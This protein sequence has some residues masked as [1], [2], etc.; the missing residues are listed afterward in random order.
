[1]EPCDSDR[2]GEFP[3][4]RRYPFQAIGHASGARTVHAGHDAAVSHS[5]D[6]LGLRRLISSS[7][8]K[9]GLLN[10]L[11]IGVGRRGRRGY[12]YNASTLI[13]VLFFSIFGLLSVG[14][15]EKKGPIPIIPCL[16]LVVAE[17]AFSRRDQQASVPA[18]EAD[19]SSPPESSPSANISRP[20]P[21]VAWGPPPPP[22]PPLSSLVGN[23]SLLES[24]LAKVRILPDELFTSTPTIALFHGNTTKSFPTTGDSDWCGPVIRSIVATPLNPVIYYLLEEVCVRD[25]KVLE[26][27]MSVRKANLSTVETEPINA[28]EDESLVVT[29]WWPFS[30][31]NGTRFS[32]RMKELGNGTSSQWMAR[33]DGLLMAADG[34]HL[35]LPTMSTGGVSAAAITS[36][37]SVDGSR[38]SVPVPAGVGTPSSY[39]L[40]P[41]Q[42]LLYITVAGPPVWLISSSVGDV[43][44]PIVD[45]NDTPMGKRPLQGAGQGVSSAKFTSQSVISDGSCLYFNDQGRQRVWGLDPLTFSTTLVA[46][47]GLDGVVNG[48]GFNASFKMLK[49]VAATPDGCDVFVVEND[50]PG[51]VRW[52]M[53]DSPCTTAKK[54][55]TPLVYTKTGLESLALHY[56]GNRLK[57]YVGT[58]DGLLFQVE[59]NKSRLHGC[60]LPQPSPPPSS[61]TDQSFF[62]N[63]SNS[64]LVIALSVFV[65]LAVS[66]GALLG[67]LFWRRRR[68]RRARGH[69]HHQPSSFAEGRSSSTPGGASTVTTSK[70]TPTSS[71]GSYCASHPPPTSELALKPFHVRQFDLAIL[72]RCTDNFHPRRRIGEKGAFGEV[73][74]ACL[75]GHGSNKEEGL[76]EGQQQEEEEQQEVEMMV[77]I[78]VMTGEL[79]KTKRNQFIAEVNTLSHINHINLIELIGYCMEGDRSILVYPYYRGGSLYE[80][81]HGWHKKQQSTVGSHDKPRFPGR[82]LTLEER[83]CITLQIAQAL[84]YLHGNVRQPILHRDIKSANVLLGDGEG[85]TLHAVLADFGLATIGE[86]VFGTDHQQMIATSHIGGTFGYMAPEYMIKG[87]LSEKNDVY[88]F[89]VLVLEIFSGRKVVW[90]AAAGPGWQTLR[91]WVKPFLS[92]SRDDDS[93]SETVSEETRT[94]TQTRTPNVVQTPT[95]DQPEVQTRNQTRNRNECKEQLP[96]VDMLKSILDPCV[97]EEVVD[98]LT[99]DMVT[100]TLRMAWECV[101]MEDVERPTMLAVVRRLQGV[102]E[103]GKIISI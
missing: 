74:K 100:G 89:G 92:R 44:L 88:A 52:L 76:E 68:R 94:Q 51:R 56:Y 85:K 18:A 95:Q 22:P 9:R 55:E 17:P 86:R 5:A 99:M 40:N 23:E 103:R 1:M 34:S 73:Y 16:A 78:K 15:R 64:N 82:P 47:S 36:L 24:E 101:S 59:I 8:I 93:L 98:T 62:R 3:S 19:P 7:S 29:H 90:P 27:L 42:T 12:S 67:G 71:W 53:L 45:D 87:E 11:V 31:Q 35:L 84:S 39:T 10:S 43:G 102:L 49:E 48:D 20:N 66:I 41:N 61:R 63:D 72:E 50:D 54:V 6:L 30:M 70:T 83:M 58:T 32:E 21:P 65:V 97:K 69:E 77:A 75:G 81:L 37:S 91:E 60:A 80:R 13:C 2:C 33:F 26:R 4:E 57:L 38:L 25:D 96:V 28:E 79:T 46:G 14:G